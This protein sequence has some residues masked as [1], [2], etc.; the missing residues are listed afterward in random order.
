[1]A[2]TYRKKTLSQDSRGNFQRDLGR[3]SDGRPQRFY[4]GKDES[5][6]ELRKL[7]LERLWAAVA[8]NKGTWDAFTLPVALA[9]ASGDSTYHVPHDFGQLKV[10]DAPSFGEASIG[11]AA[12]AFHVN[13]LAE[14][15]AGIIT[16]LPDDRDSFTSGRTG[17]QEWIGGHA[18]SLRHAAATYQAV[19][20]NTARITGAT[21]VPISGECATL[22]ECLDAYAEHIKTKPDSIDPDTRELKQ[23]ARAAR[24]H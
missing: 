18:G 21:S 23:W 13:Q 7:R 17:L 19:I 1:M 15:C 9:V 6:A 5:A 8:T 3:R 14:L 22:H 24:E 10:D 11:D 16:V 20:D 2:K 12:Y 4:L